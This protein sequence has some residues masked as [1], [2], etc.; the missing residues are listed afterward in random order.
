MRKSGTARR[1]AIFGWILVAVY[2]LLTLTPA[3]YYYASP[4]YAASNTAKSDVIVLMSSGQIDPVWLSP[5]GAQRTLGALKLYREGFA[6]FIISSG[7]HLGA[8]RHQAALQ[9]VWL[10]QAGVPASNIFIDE[11]SSRTYQSGEQ[12]SR[13]MREHGWKSAVVVVSQMD[14]PRVRRVFQKFGIPST[15]LVAPDFQRPRHFHFFA[16]WA[17]DASYHAT[18]EYAALVL[19]KLRGWI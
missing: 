9:A 6:P 10:E 17:A 15:F 1:F 5:D 19:Y 4:L 14:V 13:I 18:Y 8:G 2:F 11:R 7:S 12:V 3:A 16:R